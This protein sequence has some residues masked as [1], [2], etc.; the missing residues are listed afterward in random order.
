MNE[1]YKID[2]NLKSLQY[3][4]LETLKKIFVQYRFFTHYYIADLAILVGKLPFGSLKSILAEILNEELGN[5]N[6]N[7]A[8]PK[9]YDDFLLSIGI[10]EEM[11]EVADLNC[12][13]NLRGIQESMLNKSWAY[14]VGLRGMGGECLC[15]IYLSTM[16][17]Y[18]SKNKKITLMKDKIEWQFW[19][20][21][22][23]EIDL[24]HQKIVRAAI[25]EILVSNPETATDLMDGYLESKHA[26]DSFWQQIF[27]A[28][29]NQNVDEVLYANA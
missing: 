8:H 1:K 19:N 18:F 9:L 12:I 17:D 5:G 13:R 23:G 2:H 25:D 4:P 21:H 27:K 10:S 6:A 11:L 15:Q 16:Y 22:I 28:S 3:V 14:A 29:Q 20:I 26:W 24:H 7:H